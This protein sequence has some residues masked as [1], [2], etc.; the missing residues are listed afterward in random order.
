MRLAAFHFPPTNAGTFP[1]NMLLLH[2]YLFRLVEAFSL[3]HQSPLEFQCPS[4]VWTLS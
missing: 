3:L 4:I 2:A 1:D